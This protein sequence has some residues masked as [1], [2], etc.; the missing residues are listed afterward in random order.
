[1]P[2]ILCSEMLRAAEPDVSL[3]TT[4]LQA[5]RG[6][7]VADALWKLLTSDC[8]SI[9][10]RPHFTRRATAETNQ[11]RLSSAATHCAPRFP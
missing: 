11:T 6:D 3:G 5:V 7:E 10:A 9:S 1:M 2:D 8:L 4:L